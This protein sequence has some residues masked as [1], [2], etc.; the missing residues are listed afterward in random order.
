[1]QGTPKLRF[2]QTFGVCW[3]G[4]PNGKKS[5][6]PSQCRDKLTLTSSSSESRTGSAVRA[7]PPS[8]DPH[9]LP[10]PRSPSPGSR[11]GPTLP[12][13]AAPRTYR[14]LLL[15]MDGWMDGRNCGLGCELLL[16]QQREV[17]RLLLWSSV[18]FPSEKFN[19]FTPWKALYQQM[20]RH[21]AHPLPGTLGTALFQAAE[22]KDTHLRQ[23]RIWGGRQEQFCSETG[24]W[25]WCKEIFDEIL[26]LTTYTPK[27]YS[28][29]SWIPTHSCGCQIP[30]GDPRGLHFGREGENVWQH[31]LLC[32]TKPLGNWR[33]GN[34]FWQR[35][36][37]DLKGHTGKGPQK[38]PAPSRLPGNPS[39]P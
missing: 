25:M 30:A 23:T 6:F 29:A 10:W 9:S 39:E 15:P 4:V 24:G 34:F 13:P 5:Q 8:P 33:G 26:L 31:F 18:R 17:T 27:P 11:A 22:N 21:C 32:L 12:S 36:Y 2:S 28:E 14:P 20:L 37:P 35:R 19:S 16:S 1:M 7:L 38:F 3:L